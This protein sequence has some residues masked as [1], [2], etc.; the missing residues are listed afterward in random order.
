MLM[1]HDLFLFYFII[2]RETNFSL[3]SS[4]YFPADS[5]RNERFCFHPSA[6]THLVIYTSQQGKDY[7]TSLPYEQACFRNLVCMWTYSEGEETC[8]H[9]LARPVL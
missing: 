6:D 4:I 1:S 3:H 7:L 5:K 9:A 8:S 2:F